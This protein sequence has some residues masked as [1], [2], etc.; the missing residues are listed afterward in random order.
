VRPL[1]L[2]LV[3]VLLV[4]MYAASLWGP[5]PPGVAAIGVGDVGFLLAM[6]LLAGWADRAVTPSELAAHLPR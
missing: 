4:G 1:R 5:P 3:L 2:S 6:G